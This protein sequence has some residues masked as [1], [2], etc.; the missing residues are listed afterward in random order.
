MEVKISFHDIDTQREIIGNVWINDLQQASNIKDKQ[1]PS[2][3]S[4]KSTLGQLANAKKS[5]NFG[6]DT[7]MGE[8]D[9]FLKEEDSE[10]KNFK[11]TVTNFDKKITSRDSSMM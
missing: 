3:L 7:N 4:K 9:S 1:E 5:T 2:H 6:E 11:F 8:F 10:P